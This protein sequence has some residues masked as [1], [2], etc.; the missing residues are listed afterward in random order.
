[1]LN[2]CFSLIKSFITGLGQELRGAERLFFPSPQ[3][4]ALKTAWCRN[5]HT[6]M[7]RH[8]AQQPPLSNLNQPIKTT[9]PFTT[10][11]PCPIFKTSRA[12]YNFYEEAVL[13]A[14]S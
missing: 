8:T 14:C 2:F 12:I 1:M 9:P 11:G 5:P 6:V 7:G 3:G 10:A 4:S 13:A